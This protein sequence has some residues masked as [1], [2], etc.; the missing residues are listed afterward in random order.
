MHSTPQVVVAGGGLA[1]LVAARHLAAAGT[2]VTLFERRETTGGRVRTLERDGF[3]FDRGFQVCFT[4]YPAVRRELDLT[5]LHL[6]RF[7]PGATVAGPDGLSTLAD[8]LREPGTIPATLSNPYVSAGDALRVARLWYRLRRTD[9]GDIFAGDDERI[10]DFLRTR[11]FSDR[12]I[13]GFVAPF[14][15]GITLD[16]SLATSRRVFEYTFRTLA[17][18]ETVVPAAGMEAIPAQLADCVREVG[19]TI[20]TGT[21]VESVAAD[22][23]DASDSTGSVTVETDAEPLEADAVVVATDPPTAR[24]LTGVESIPT[25]A[26]SCVTQ[27]YALPAGTDLGTGRR[28]LLNATGWGPNHVVP[29]SAVA[30]EYAPADATLIS[31]TYLGEQPASDEDLAEQTRRSLESWSPNREFDD[32]ETLHTERIPFA[33]FDQP[34]GI[35][36]RLPDARDPAGS[37]YLAGDY[38]QWSSI[39]GA[40]ESGRRAAEAVIDDLSG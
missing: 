38:T 3:R 31:A 23:G 26:R 4:A 15:G 7:A 28:L 12:F 6:R 2:D 24:D 30:P 37:V 5:A 20:R 40:M 29:H 22:G 34:P 21:T 1:G 14:Y 33:Q 17:A 32:L 19:G 39:Q 13:E 25:E 16:R 36:D 11:G 35:H 9:P 10:D 8:P 27:Y 18:G